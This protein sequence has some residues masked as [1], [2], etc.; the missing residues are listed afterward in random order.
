MRAYIKQIDITPDGKVVVSGH[1]SRTNLNVRLTEH[2]YVREPDDGIW[3]YT[4]EVIP[5]SV[6][7]ADMMVPF[8][9]A[10]PWTGNQQSNGVRISQPTIDPSEP[11]YETVQLKVKKVSTYSTSQAN[12][13]ILKGASFDKSTGQLIIDITY[14]G[15]CFP[16][17]FSLE[18]DGSS[19]ESAPP[20][21]N[22]TLVD[23][24][25]Y[26]ACRALLPA[27]LRFDISTPGVQLDM[28]SVINLGTIRQGNQ[29][30]V[31]IGV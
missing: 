19:L 27:Q 4:L 17:L 12:V 3:G 18:W 2:L 16:H 10:A 31:E 8:A 6:F 5:T 15:G 1:L 24:S 7:G 28:P 14:S 11:D 26:D 25:E 13:I 30:R 29:I 20:Q 23:I 21:Y 9:V 22:F